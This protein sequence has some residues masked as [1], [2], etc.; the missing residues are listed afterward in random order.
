MSFQTIVAR[1]AEHQRVGSA[2]RGDGLGQ[3]SIEP[4]IG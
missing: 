3:M 4:G 2:Q 1:R